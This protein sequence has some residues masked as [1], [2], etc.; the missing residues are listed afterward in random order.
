MPQPPQVRRVFPFNLQIFRN[1]PLDDVRG[2]FQFARRRLNEERLP[3]VA[4]SLT[5]TT[6]LALVPIFAIAFA[7]FTTFPLFNT[8]RA[9]LE[10]YFIKSLMPKAIANTIL[11]YL[12]QFASKATR[13][14]AIGAV[15]LILTAIVMMLTIDRAFNHIWRVKTPRTM[16]QRLVIYWA[17]VTLG[18]LLIGVSISFTSGLFRATNDFGISFPLIG[19]TF[20][21]AL[22]VLLTMGAFTLLYIAVPNR[23]V[24]WRDAACGGLLAAT[25]FEIAKRVFVIFIT[26]FPAY[27]VLYGALAAI[28]IF[29]LWIYVSWLI[30]LMGGVLAAALPIVKYERWWHV[31]TPGSAF[32]D[33]MAILTVLH[34][35]RL[36]GQSSAVDARTLRALTRLGF[37]ESEALLEKMLDAGWVGRIKAEPPRRVRIGKRVAEGLDTWVL[38]A[39]PE[40]LRVADVYR[41][42]VF[43]AGGNAVLAKQVEAAVEQGLHASLADHFAAGKVKYPG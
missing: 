38:L 2:L 43:N 8:F 21:T 4:G 18:P 5:F 13:L 7:I 1:F 24:D 17:I 10:A 22:S 42:F 9:A 36:K 33:A 25:A 15:G 41:L 29:L 39:N 34:D 35:A 12:N 32:I 11:G 27:T 26:N 37:D 6:V 3:Q 23:S 28:P 19:A 31:A 14:S 40:Q 30:T 16:S 20:Y